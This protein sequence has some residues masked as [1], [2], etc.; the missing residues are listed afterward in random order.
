M[1]KK[2]RKT[3]KKES[4]LIPFILIN[5]LL[6]FVF[7]L[8]LNFYF[9]FFHKAKIQVLS[10][11]IVNLQTVSSIQR[12]LNFQFSGNVD[13][14]LI[15][16]SFKITPLVLGV[17][18][19]KDNKN[20]SYQFEEH[21]QGKTRYA[22]E[23]AYVASPTPF[24]PTT[25]PE[26]FNL[27]FE[28]GEPPEIVSSSPRDAETNVSLNK[29][30]IFNFDKKIKSQK[31]SDYFLIKPKTEGALSA[32]GTRLIFTPKEKLKQDTAYFAGVLKGLAE[33][34]D[35]QLTNDYFI[36]FRTVDGSENGGSTTED[37]KANVPIL[38]YHNVGAW[39]LF[40]PRIMKRF[41]IEPQQL[42]NHLKFISENYHTISMS[43]LYDFLTNDIPLPEHPV[44][45]TFDDGW[46]GLYTDAFPI[47]KKYHLHFTAYLISS[48]LDYNSGYLTKR[49]VR[50]M[51][52]SGLMELGNHT[53]NHA[54]LG[55]FG[56][57]V[58]RKEIQD[59]EQEL[60]DDFGVTPLT[61]AYPGG[62][63]NTSV[64]DEV[65]NEGFNTAVTVKA[66]TIQSENELM[67]LKRIEIEGT[68]TIENI[69]TK[70]EK[71]Y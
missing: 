65:E 54:I 27:Q 57:D 29:Y 23:F 39:S 25:A 32:K 4:F 35:Q 19:W 59:A 49:E 3:D 28:T 58:I 41:K 33:E 17:M 11:S 10:S 67:F 30:I 43:N 55:F 56:K 34:N 22:V 64:I 36:K 20:F 69:R 12:N 8:V 40:E 47:L 5:A 62:S 50:E 9:T 42:E 38:M 66:G 45:L 61:F 46:R 60:Q 31:L 6:V 51:L 1:P 2:R 24:F 18:T 15:E 63:Y 48:Y 71:E 26:V 14:Q 44:I 13:R 37:R 52:K 53:K 70:I 68:D 21:L 7:L 16:R